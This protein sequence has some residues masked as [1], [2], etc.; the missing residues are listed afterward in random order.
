ME[1]ELWLQPWDE[2]RNGQEI[3]EWGAKPHTSSTRGSCHQLQQYLL[4]WNS[5]PKAPHLLASN[6]KSEI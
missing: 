1:A 4:S 2:R 3:S 5:G 6:E